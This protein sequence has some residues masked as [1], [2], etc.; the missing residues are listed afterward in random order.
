[1]RKNFRSPAP[2]EAEMALIRDDAIDAQTLSTR[3]LITEIKEKG[4]LLARKEIELAKTEIRADLQSELAMVKGLGVAAVLALLSLGQFL[5]A[6]VAALAPI[7]A[8]WLSALVIALI[9]L[10][11]A[12]IA[13]YI[14]WSR[15][16]S[17]PL[18]LTRKT[19][20]ED[21]QW[22]KERLA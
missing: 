4:T 2:E 7:V 13:G 18:A 9:L 17:N 1:M 10:L 20:K 22:A 21:M 16:V 3:E 14:G 6:A 19:V 15:R 11:G 8:P 12:A 5:L